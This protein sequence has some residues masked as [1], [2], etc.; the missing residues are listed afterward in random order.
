MVSVRLDQVA[1]LFSEGVE[2][3]QPTLA[4]R[5]RQR[6][7]LLHERAGGRAQR[8][9]ATLAYAT[10]SPRVNS[11]AAALK[12]GLFATA[13]SLHWG[14]PIQTKP[15][16]VLTAYAASHAISRPQACWRPIRRAVCCSLQSA[17]PPGGP[18]HDVGSAQ[19]GRLS[20]EAEDAFALLARNP[21]DGNDGLRF[22]PDLGRLR[23]GANHDPARHRAQSDAHLRQ[24]L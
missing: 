13:S 18:L 12:P 3:E 10:S 15:C 4:E 23:A 6:N 16:S 20:Q 5:R 17:R 22:R 11:L 1:Q 14:R 24:I 8:I 7:A 19:P 21:R 2:A 9:R